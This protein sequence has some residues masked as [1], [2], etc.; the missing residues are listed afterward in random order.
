MSQLII[1]LTPK[2]KLIIQLARQLIVDPTLQILKT[3]KKRIPMI[4]SLTNYSDMIHLV[5]I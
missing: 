4:S 2:R 1:L 3:E 5:A